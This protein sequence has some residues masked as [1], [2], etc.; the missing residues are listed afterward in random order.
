M[1]PVIPNHYS[2]RLSELDLMTLRH[3]PPGGNWKHVPSTVP[4]KRLESIRA[5]FRRGEGS[6]STYYGRL[7]P[8]A[9]SYTINT[10]F[11]RPGNGCH[12]H[13]SQDRVLSQREAARLQSFPDN[14]RFLGSARDVN[15]QIGNAVPPLLAYQLARQLGEPGCF[16]D[17]F[18]GAG[19]LSLGFRWAGWECVVASDI[20]PKFLETHQANLGGRSLVGDINDPSVVEEIVRLAQEGRRRDRQFIV[21]GGPPC[22]GFSTAGNR[23]SVDD[24][25][26]HLFLSYA[27]LLNRLSPDGFLFENVMGLLNMEQGRLFNKVREVLA[28]AAADLA[29][30]AVN[31]EKYGVPQRRSRVILVGRAQGSALD[32]PPPISAFPAEVAVR[33][34]VPLT[35]SV[36]DALSDLPPL[37]PGED[38]STL[39]YAS[40]PT[41]AYQRLARGEIRPDDYLASLRESP[42]VEVR[43][44]LLPLA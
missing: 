18:S 26:N 10:Y 13:Y 20:E 17:L 16:V 14:F 12:I 19:G 24:E 30:W 28:A 35:P 5:S 4:S 25:R 42:L 9:P 37:T 6:R 32:P 33:R 44:Q 1:G 7:R 36:V 15:V 21:L 22:Q 23:R 41:T 31:A 43:Q 39:S 38:G 34:G 27:S 40:D 8:D 2:A 3:I 11:S 29:V